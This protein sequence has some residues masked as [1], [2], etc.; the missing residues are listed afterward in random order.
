MKNKKISKANRNLIQNKTFHKN[1][2]KKTSLLCWK[3]LLNKIK[4]SLIETIFKPM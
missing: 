3:D 4:K 1:N 2:Q